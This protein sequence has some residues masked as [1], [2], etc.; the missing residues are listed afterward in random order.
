M[1]KKLNIMTNLKKDHNYVDYDINQLVELPTF[2]GVWEL[3]FRDI[4]FKMINIYN[5]D[6]VPTKFFWKDKYEQLL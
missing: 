6:L 2:S 1:E 4:Y 5:D 3:K